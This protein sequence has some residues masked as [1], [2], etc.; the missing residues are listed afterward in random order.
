M[1]RRRATG[2]QGRARVLR[3]TADRPAQRPGR[4]RQSHH[5]SAARR[6]PRQH[7]TRRTA[8]NGVAVP[9][10]VADVARELTPRSYAKYGVYL[11]K[12]QPHPRE[13]GRA[14]V[15]EEGAVLVEDWI[16]ALPG[17]CGGPLGGGGGDGGGVGFLL[18]SA[19]LRRVP[20][21][22]QQAHPSLG[23][24]DEIGERALEAPPTAASPRRS[25]AAPAL[26]PLFRAVPPPRHDLVE[27]RR[28]WPAALDAVK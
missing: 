22:Q 8:R 20:R 14:V 2:H 4:V 6:A 9:C 5:G 11:A 27:P 25:T 24:L 19:V 23:D 3:R 10:L 26:S 28:R 17:G 21:T 1:R 7:A 12:L 15:H 18:G 13:L 16:R